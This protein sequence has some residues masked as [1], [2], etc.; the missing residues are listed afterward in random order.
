MPASACPCCGLPVLQPGMLCGHCLSRKPFFDET[1]AVFLYVQ[2]V[3]DMVL[4]LKHARGFPLLDWLAE[5]MT[6]CLTGIFADCLVPV[7]LH[8]HRLSARG[9]NQSC[10]LARR[11][12]RRT[13][14]HVLPDV[15]VRQT[16]TPRLAGLHARQRLLRIKGA[17]RLD[18]D[19]SGKT[20]IVVD[21][22]MTSGATLNEIARVLK[23]AGVSRVINLVL[24][25]T[26]S[27][28]E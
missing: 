4:S 6:G 8:R 5:E 23:Q 13:G 18:S 14:I 2:P 26:L 24:A 20:V 3:R 27:G 25:R 7:P 11:I 17:F 10:E 9:F 15:L 1:H 21:D 28:R 16:D 19:L 22:V 12:A